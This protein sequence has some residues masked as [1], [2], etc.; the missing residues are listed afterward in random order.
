MTLSLEANKLALEISLWIWQELVEA[1]EIT[2]PAGRIILEEALDLSRQGLGAL[3]EATPV[4][5][6][7]A[8]EA[9][10]AW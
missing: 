5:I 2:G 9:Q 4:F 6:E 1:A 3:I 10:H 7:R 8:N